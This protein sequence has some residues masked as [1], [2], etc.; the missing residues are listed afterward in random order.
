MATTTQTLKIEEHP[1][2]EE[3]RAPSAEEIRYEFAR[4][5]FDDVRPDWEGVT[6][7]PISGR[8]YDGFTALAL[9]FQMALQ[10]AMYA[11]LCDDTRY[12]WPES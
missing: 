2:W 6:F 7:T 5:M 8:R 3:L 1:I 11:A 4:S 9:A 12:G 10:Y